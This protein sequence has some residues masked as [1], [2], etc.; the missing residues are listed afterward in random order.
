MSTRN[1][2]SGSARHGYNRWEAVGYNRESRGVARPGSAP[3]LGAEKVLPKRLSRT[4]V[5]LRNWPTAGSMSPLAILRQQ[6]ASAP[7]ALPSKGSFFG[8][9]NA[10]E[11]QSSLL[12]AGCDH[13]ESFKSLSCC[14]E[15][16]SSPRSQL[17]WPSTAADETCNRLERMR[18][19]H[20][21]GRIASF[22]SER[23]TIATDRT[24][25]E[26]ASANFHDDP[27]ATPALRDFVLRFA[28]DRETAVHMPLR[29]HKRSATNPHPSLL[30]IVTC[31][32]GPAGP[33]K[34]DRANIACLTR[35]G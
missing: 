12:S 7:K 17:L 18:A 11:C 24:R 9:I 14:A 20:F 33:R 8:W 22:I 28:A 4:L 10:T 15:L 1:Y 25:C 34:Q 21:V 19:S 23:L 3:A 27:S 13:C 32:H 31:F 30:R 16:L 6:R 2:T 29:E 35:Q 26:S 5:S